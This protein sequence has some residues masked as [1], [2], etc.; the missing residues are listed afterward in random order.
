[1]RASQ[2]ARGRHSPQV[3]GHWLPTHGIHD[4][5]C[6]PCHT[7]LRVGVPL[8][9]LHRLRRSLRRWGQHPPSTARQIVLAQGVRRH[10]RRAP[11]SPRHTHRQR[12]A[13]ASLR[14]PQTHV[15]RCAPAN[16]HRSQGT[17]HALHR[18]VPTPAALHEAQQISAHL[19]RLQQPWQLPAAPA[20]PGSAPARLRPCMLPE[21]PV[22]S[23]CG[24]R[25]RNLVHAIGLSL[26]SSHLHVLPSY[27]HTK[28]FPTIYAWLALLPPRGAAC[29]SGLLRLISQ[30]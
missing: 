2:A 1:V 10:T 17:A 23:A 11:C 18:H 28:L 27:P 7:A 25:N 9:L 22:C 5:H 4:V 16:I 3:G 6:A 21:S 14:P 20:A 8:A 30:F 26:R 19:V 29:Q 24:G 12:V 13:L 15:T